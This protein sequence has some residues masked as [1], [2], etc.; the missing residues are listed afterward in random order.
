MPQQPFSGE[1]IRQID[2]YGPVPRQAVQD[3]PTG[4]GTTHLRIGQAV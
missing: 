3:V 2:F 1:P 4:A